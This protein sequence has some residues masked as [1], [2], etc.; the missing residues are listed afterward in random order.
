[1]LE[2]VE[3]ILYHPLAATQT[4]PGAKMEGGVRTGVVKFIL[5]VLISL[6]YVYYFLR[7]H[8]LPV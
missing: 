6:G 8:L 5:R 3:G 1:M 2:N 7:C 4:G